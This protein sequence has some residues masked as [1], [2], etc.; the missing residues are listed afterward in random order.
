MELFL[1]AKIHWDLDSLYADLTSIKTLELTDWEKNC[2]RGLLCGIHPETIASKMFWTI[3][4]LKTELSRRL[5]PYIS[6]LVDEKIMAWHKVPKLLEKAG[7]KYPEIRSLSKEL[8][9]LEFLSNP[10]SS[11]KSIGAST[12]IELLEKKNMANSAIEPDRSRE[13]SDRELDRIVEGDCYLKAEDFIEA[14]DCYRNALTID[15]LNF[16]VLIKVA[17]CYER[18]EFYRDALFI[19]DFA[20]DRI[21]RDENKSHLQK[22]YNKSIVYYFIAGLFHKLAVNKYCDNYVQIAFETYQK[23]LYLRPQNIMALWN[24]V[25]L[26]ISVMRHSAIAPELKND[27]MD[28]AKKALSDFKGNARQ[29]DFNFKPYRDPILEKAENTFQGLDYWWQE[30]LHELRSW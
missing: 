6:I 16:S 24:I 7:Y 15:P 13:L 30:Q 10:N 9:N 17:K 1:H 14:I 11:F 25:D 22:T 27:Y 28:R 29:L 3:S 8:F 26:F 2:L 23:Y 4:A 21:E 18:L 12:I 5:Y 19:C 20:L